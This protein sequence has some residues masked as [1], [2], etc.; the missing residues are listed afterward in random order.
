MTISI[1][2]LVNCLFVIVSFFI[3]YTIPN[4]KNMG[5]E[6]IL[7]IN[8]QSDDLQ[9]MPEQ[10]TLEGSKPSAVSE[11][12]EA[13]ENEEK[14][15]ILIVDDDRWIQ[16]IFNQYLSGWGFEHVEAFDSFE[17]MDQ[18][19]RHKP[20]MIFLDIIMP[21]V[22]GDITL[23]FLSTVEITKDIP[24]VIISG[25][26]NKDVLKNTYRDGAAGFLSKPFTKEVLLAKIVNVLDDEI[27]KKMIRSGLIEPKLVKEALGQ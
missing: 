18:A 25:N 22:T 7:D 3:K 6:K 15:P 27:I 23:K 24:V 26:L 19:I 20:L 5:D 4:K 9:E 1:S 11:N 12:Q 21:E 16:R 14:F 17:G 10:E 2:N 8:L 13:K